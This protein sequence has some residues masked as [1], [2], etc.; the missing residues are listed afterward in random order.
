[1]GDK[2]KLIHNICP[3]CGSEMTWDKMDFLRCPDCSSESHMSVD[4]PKEFRRVVLK[5][6]SGPPTYMHVKS[7]KGGSKSS[8]GRSTAKEKLKRESNASMFKKLFVET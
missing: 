5:A 8:K 2:P 4:S 3:Y 6:T 1:M 7:P